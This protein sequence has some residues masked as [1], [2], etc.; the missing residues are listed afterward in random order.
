M[1]LEQLQEKLLDIDDG[2]DTEDL[3]SEGKDEI[4]HYLYTSYDID[5]LIELI[6]NADL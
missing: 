6:K 5:R 2:I 1:T 3:V 4:I